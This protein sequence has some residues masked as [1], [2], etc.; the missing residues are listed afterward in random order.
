MLKPP[1]RREEK[2]RD[3]TEHGTRSDPFGSFLTDV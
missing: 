1:V 2:R 3:R